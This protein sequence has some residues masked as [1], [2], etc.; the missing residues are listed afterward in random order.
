[1]NGIPAPPKATAPAASG[2][3][4]GDARRQKCRDCIPTGWHLVPRE[5]DSSLFNALGFDSAFMTHEE[6]DQTWLEVLEAASRIISR[7][8]GG[9]NG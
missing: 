1:M 5:L 6:A 8:Q 7:E 2:G 4:D 9:R 3:E